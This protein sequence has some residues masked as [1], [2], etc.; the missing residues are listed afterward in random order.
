MKRKLLMTTLMLTL[1]VCSILGLTA[2]GGNNDNGNNSGGGNSTIAVTSITLNRSSLNLEIGDTVSL[3][4]TI[5]PSNATDKSVT[6]SSSNT[7]VAT[8]SNGTVTAKSSGTASITVKTSNNKTAICYVT[9]NNSAPQT[10]AVSSVSLNK[11]SAT[12]EVGDTLSLYATISPSNATDKSVTWSSSNTSVATVSNGL[13]TAKSAGTATI[14]VK[15]SNNKT[16]TC[17][18]TVKNQ[19]ILPTAIYL[20]K[21]SVELNEGENITLTTTILPNN[22]TNKVVEWIVLDTSIATVNNGIITAKS[23]GET[24]LIATTV[25]GLTSTCSIVVKSQLVFTE[26]GSG[27]ALIDYTGTATSLTVPSTYKGKNVVAIGSGSNTI[28]GF[29]KNTE[30]KEVI[31]PNTVKTL[32]IGAFAKCS[33]LVK[34]VMKGVEIVGQEAFKY[35]SSLK[36][37]VMENVI[38]I[39]YGAFMECIALENIVLPNTVNTVYRDA[40]AYCRELKTV[41]LS[42]NIAGWGMDVFNGCDKIESI[43]APFDKY[44]LEKY[45]DMSN[46][47]KV[48]TTLQAITFT[49]TMIP[50]GWSR[51]EESFRRQIKDVMIA[52]SVTVVEANAFNYLYNLK[53][54]YYSGNISAWCVIDFPS[55]FSFWGADFYINNQKVVNL[56]IPDGVEKINPYAFKECA[57]LTSVTIGNSVKWIGDSAFGWCSKL[58][59]VTIG[60]SVT[61][62]G[63]YAF[64]GYNSLTSVTIGN[65]VKW[66]GDYAFASCSSLTSIKYRGTA[67]QWQAISRGS[68]W[69]YNTGNYTITYNYRG[70]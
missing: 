3:Y 14:T 37:V 5:Y 31:L 25:N 40:L 34:V 67:S 69:N 13:V 10:V 48:P 42:N 29:Y 22:V 8:V 36:E 20:S 30:I 24:T 15:T 47:G 51:L 64:C 50:G 17:Y 55:N 21:S 19:E 27:Y 39:Q 11:T 70:N 60:N 1:A 41:V 49:G 63:E 52:D 38:T 53:S 56:V 16:A 44:S 62:I 61:S 45:F 59:S 23:E 46:G 9:V 54:V 12:L 43:S 57:S 33:S 4:E 58:T 32:N 35:C 7:S 68:R 28:N 65:S 2:C 18:V 26:Y 66:I 6:W